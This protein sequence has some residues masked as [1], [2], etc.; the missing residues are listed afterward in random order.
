[1]ERELN[2]IIGNRFADLFILT[3]KVVRQSLDAG[4]VVSLRGTV[5][6]SFGAFLSGITEVNSLPPHYVCP[7]CFATEFIHFDQWG[8]RRA[9][10]L[11]GIEADVG[12]DL[13]PRTCAAC[14]APMN[15]SGF[16]IPFETFVGFNGEKIPD[17]DLSFADEC[18]A[19]ALQFVKELLGHDQVVHA[20]TVAT[21]RHNTAFGLAKNYLETTGEQ[22]SA[23]ETDRVT[24]G[25]KGVK[26][27]TGHLPGGIIV[28][29]RDR[30]VTEFCPVNFPANQHDAPCATHFDYHALFVQ[31]RQRSGRSSVPA[32]TS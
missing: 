6:S 7:S 2:A 24:E 21:I 13:P 11:D 32:T 10:P 31:A 28:L 9:T 19:R 8:S 12:V 29:P 17:I 16:D 5:G 27:T 22:W 1:M 15:R 14:K 26:R 25:L 20:G 3:R 23:A 4:Y 30:K 18:Q